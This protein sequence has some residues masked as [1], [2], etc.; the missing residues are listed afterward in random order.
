[1]GK[2][3]T[4]GAVVS[5]RKSVQVY[6]YLVSPLY[7]ES[8]MYTRIG[9]VYFEYVFVQFIR[10][11]PTTYVECKIKVFF[12]RLSILGLDWKPMCAPRTW[13]LKLQKNK[14]KKIPATTTRRSYIAIIINNTFYIIFRIYKNYKQ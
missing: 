11:P 9:I 7:S 2:D 3:K 13:M 8:K 1:M 14:N 10:I 6:Q 12:T 4:F 5:T